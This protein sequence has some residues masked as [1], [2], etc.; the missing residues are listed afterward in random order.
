MSHLPALEVLAMECS[1][2]E[3]TISSASLV[4]AVIKGPSGGSC[5]FPVRGPAPQ[6]HSIGHSL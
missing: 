2:V 6:L 4:K 1:Q 5:P 3:G